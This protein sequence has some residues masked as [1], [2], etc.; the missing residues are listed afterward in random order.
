MTRGD[1]LIERGAERLRQLSEQMAARGGAAANLADELAE[2]AEFLRRLKPSLIIARARGELRTDQDPSTEA[3]APSGPQ[4]SKRPK[5]GRAGAGPN[6]FV[7]VGAALA[8]GIVLA[9]VIDWRGHAHP[10]D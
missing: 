2:D 6:P 5:P 10:R 1:Q 7:I 8:V 3:R 9:K 4:I